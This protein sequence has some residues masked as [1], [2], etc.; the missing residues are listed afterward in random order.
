VSQRQ[1]VWTS[2][3][4]SSTRGTSRTTSR[5]TGTRRSCSRLVR[6]R[7]WKSRSWRPASIR[8]SARS[9]AMPPPAW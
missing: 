3:S 5:S 2:P 6:H 1:E 7:P 8:I 4:S 9:Q